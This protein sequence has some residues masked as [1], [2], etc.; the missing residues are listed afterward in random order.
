MLFLRLLF[1]WTTVFRVYTASFRYPCLVR[2]SVLNPYCVKVLRR[3]AQ[4]PESH[5]R[6]R[7]ADSVLAILK[8]FVELKSAD[9]EPAEKV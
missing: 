3:Y 1:R 7:A 2:T 6:E 9:P 4:S 5:Q 8:K